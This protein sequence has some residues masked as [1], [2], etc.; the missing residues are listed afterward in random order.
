MGP[1]SLR[2]MFS[3]MPY[4]CTWSPRTALLFAL[5]CLAACSSDSCACDGFVPGPF[6]AEHFNKT[7]PGSAQVR[8]TR[9]GLDFLESEL[10]NLVGEATGQGLDF[11][12]PADTS[13]SPE[14]CHESTT[15]ADG[16]PGCPIT[17]SIDDTQITTAPPQGMNIAVTI[18]DINETIPFAWRSVD[19][20]ARL[21]KKGAA[22]NVPAQVL[23]EVPVSFLVDG[24]SPTRDLRVELGE[25]LVNLD[26]L[27]IKLRGRGNFL[28][29]LVCGGANLLVGI[30]RGILE[31]EIKSAIN[32][33]ITEVSREQ[34][35]QTCGAG[36]PACPS[37]ATCQDVDGTPMCM[38]NA[39]SEC[40]PRVLGVEGRLDLAAALQGYT[41]TAQAATDL[42]FKAADEPQIDTGLTL[43][44]RSGF[45]PPQLARCAP[46][47]PLA[48]PPFGPVSLSPT[49]A[50]G[51]NPRTSQPFMFGIGVH[52]LTLQQMFWSIWASGGLC[53]Q[54]GSDTVEQLSTGAIGALLPSV[55]GLADG[56]S[57]M[58]IQIT[59][60]TAPDVKLGANRVSRDGTTYRL[61]DPLMTVLWQDLDIHMYAYI[62]DRYTRLL[63]I[64]TDVEL[65]VGIVP[66]AGG[67]I[68]PVL[69]DIAGAL[70]NIRPLNAGLIAENPQRLADLL[71]TLF[72]LA[73]PSLT[74]A[75]DRSIEVPDLLGYRLALTQDDITSVDDNNFIALFANLEPIPPP[76]MVTELRAMVPAWR[77]DYAH[78]SPS[79][80]VRP[81][82]LLNLQSHD[83]ALGLVPPSRVEYSVRVNQGPWS[84]FDG[85]RELVIDNPVLTLQGEHL[86]E[87][88]AR[89]VGVVESVQ[90]LATGFV[91]RVDYEKPA[92]GFDAQGAFVVFEG[93]DAVDGREALRWR[94]RVTTVPGLAHWTAWT[95]T[96]R[97]DLRTL[98]GHERVRL[99]VQVQDRA[100]HVTTHAETVHVK[101]LLS[102]LAPGERALAEETSSCGGCSAQGSG[103]GGPMGMLGWLGLA[104]LVLG[105]RRRRALGLQTR[106]LLG[107][108]GRVGAVALV[109]ISLWGCSDDD[110]ATTR[111]CPEAC[112]GGFACVND[113][114]VANA[115][116]DDAECGE[117]IC[118]NGFCAPAQCTEASQCAAGCEA[119]EY[120]S[121][122]GG[123]CEC[124]DYCAGG[125]GEEQFCCRQTDSCQD[126]TD[127][128]AQT[129][130]EPGFE[131]KIT[132][133]GEANETSCEVTGGSCEC[134]PLPELPVGLMGRYVSVDANAQGVRAAAAYNQTYGDLVVASVAQNLT[135]TWYWVDG[136][137]ASGTIAGRVD[138]P[139]GGLRDRGDN[140]GQYPAIAVDAQG[141]LHIVYRDRDKKTL[142]YARGT[143]AA[144]GTY[145]FATRVLD[146]KGD[147]GHWSAAR[148]VGDTLHYVYGVYETTEQ[149][150]TPPVDT[151]DT[152]AGTGDADAG[153]GDAGADPVQPLDTDPAP[154]VPQTQIR[155]A[156]FDVG[157]AMEALGDVRWKV[158]Y[159]MDSVAQ[160]SGPASIPWQT[161]LFMQ[162]A[163]APQGLLLVFYDHLQQ[164]VAWARHID[165]N[166]EMPQFVGAQSG[167][168]G[169]GQVDAEGNV[170]LAYMDRQMPALVYWTPGQ[171]AQVIRDGARDTAQ[172]WHV[173]DIG[174]GVR[175]RLAQDGTMTAV[176]QD[177]TLH[178]L[179]GAVRAPGAA[180][181]NVTAIS[182]Q[183]GQ[184]AGSHGFYGGLMAGSTRGI[185]AEYVLYN[186]ETP[187]RAAVLFHNVP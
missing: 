42:M 49:I 141:H 61:D 140:V 64:R 179:F 55:R 36:E 83:S 105:L 174:E 109:A 47:D 154:T 52:K 121:C 12:L 110:V 29:D 48:R 78:K 104:S 10:P 127:W 16:S 151:P 162:L 164:S 111:G 114:C 124:T 88:R 65:P 50:S 38:Y 155:Y 130:C 85:A 145:S 62:Q 82:L 139:R 102:S 41:R 84:M 18:G 175:L 80:L 156:S 125:C 118:K 90:Q 8:L 34:L 106:H 131:A 66:E 161:G 94:H 101:Q 178:V 11:C 168:Y 4:L 97:L 9:Q 115:C 79:G 72:G 100:G 20:E 44:F 91:V 67:T 28:D 30:L 3:R 170:H 173:A 75:L 21:H 31:D 134:V 27:D 71:P 39:T 15:C 112:G 45:Q 158:V 54:V 137:P 185:A 73:L 19:C 63:T 153:T 14:L 166:W 142:K 95:T 51:V 25:V 108:L 57:A 169:A 99:E 184:S 98:A 92:L 182:G 122:N 176:F 1:S 129:T 163:D 128:C 177:A 23:A 171:P 2:Q 113:Q 32:D 13:G 40:V 133:R 60:Q 135:P 56:P 17:L 96:D 181:W 69:G 43:Q 5:M 6:P 160:P 157:T 7:V 146:D 76:A 107:R 147:A 117:N 58:F 180:V 24:N 165:G 119:D 46:V 150:A 148:I 59:P 89:Y 103:S 53:L 120:P 149:P 37:S 138:G 144:N 22:D 35:C 132:A 136:V 81:R 187:P 167:P 68:R 33:A 74:A 183:D 70:T 86:V 93:Q 116:T 152:D 26:D 123:R 77:L 186:R 126:Y 143:R 87:V 159:Q 172:G